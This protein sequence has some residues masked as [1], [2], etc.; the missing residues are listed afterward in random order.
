MVEFVLVS[1][2]LQEKK[3][4]LRCAVRTP[5]KKETV[6]EAKYDAKGNPFWSQKQLI[7]MEP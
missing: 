3:Q 6:H 1:A 7:E 2:F 5:N 4:G